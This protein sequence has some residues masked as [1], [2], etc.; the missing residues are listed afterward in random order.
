MASAAAV[1]RGLYLAAVGAASWFKER[2]NRTPLPMIDRFVISDRERAIGFGS[3]SAPPSSGAEDGKNS[4]R[5]Q[6]VSVV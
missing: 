3:P 4:L 2:S 1:A 6:D 5:I